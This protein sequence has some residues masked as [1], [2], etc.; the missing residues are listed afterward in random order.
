[1]RVL[2]ALNVLMWHCINEVRDDKSFIEIERVSWRWNYSALFSKYGCVRN[3]IIK[4]SLRLTLGAVCFRA[5][6][7]SRPRGAIRALTMQDSIIESKTIYY[8][9]FM[10]F[11]WC[12][13]IF[14]EERE[15]KNKTA[16]STIF[17][18]IN[19]FRLY[20]RI[21]IVSAIS[22]INRPNARLAVASGVESEEMN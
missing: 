7:R 19:S 18:I 16:K 20:D 10:V 3:W 2:S 15:R 17:E 4:L 1:M 6:A 12:G 9:L 21:C 8:T 11:C 22:R 14:I 5:Y 13:Y